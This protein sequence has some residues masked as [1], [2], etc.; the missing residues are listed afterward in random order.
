[1]TSP[2]PQEHAGT[3]WV[4]WHRQYADPEHA[5]SRRLR[6]IQQQIG[7]YLDAAPPSD[8]SILSLCAGQGDDLIGVLPTHPARARVRAN[9][10][11][12]EEGNVSVA[13]ERIARLGLDQVEVHQAD[14][15]LSDTYAGL[16]PA[17][18]V[19][20]CGVF[21]NV[22]DD[23]VATTVAALPQL[24][25]ANATVLWTRHRRAPDLTPSINEWFAA[26]GFEKLRL[27]SPDDNGFAVGTHRL[28]GDSQPL[29]L[30]ERWFRF[31]DRAED[32]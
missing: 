30:S 26:A 19:L 4:A 29:K 27:H 22:T 24:C 13:R 17:D 20:A 12:L 15:G 6:D 3:W 7:A 5:L 14:A 23:A 1:V 25:T 31:V 18:F 2:T 11:E 8:L 28:V 10:V 16:V 21:G 32:C 9:L